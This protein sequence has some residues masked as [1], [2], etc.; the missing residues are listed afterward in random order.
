VLVTKAPKLT[1]E[2]N[3]VGETPLCY[4]CK[5]FAQY[6]VIQFLIYFDSDAVII[7]DSLGCTPLYHRKLMFFYTVFN[8]EYRLT[9]SKKNKK[10]HSLF[11]SYE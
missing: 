5:I 8:F 7:A 9:V 11:I 3:H 10:I 6:E 4:A 1:K 2:I